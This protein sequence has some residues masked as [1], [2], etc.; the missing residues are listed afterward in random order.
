MSIILRLSCLTAT[1]II[2]ITVTS[3]V[4]VILGLLGFVSSPFSTSA[5][6]AGTLYVTPAGTNDAPC[7]DWTNACQLQ[8]AL[9]KATLGDNIWVAAGIYYPGTT[10]SDTFKLKDGVAIYG[11]FTGTETTLQQRDWETNVTI[12][13]GDIDQNDT[14]NEGIIE[15]IEHIKGK[16]AAYVVR[17]TGVTTTTLLDGFFITAATRNGIHNTNSNTVFQNMIIRGNTAS[18]GGGGGMYNFNSTTVLSNVTFLNN[19]AAY[20]GGGM[21]NTNSRVTMQKVAFRENLFGAMVNDGSTLVITDVT[22][23]HNS[24]TGMSNRKSTIKMVHGSFFGNTGTGMDN[25]ESDVSL[26]SGSILGSRNGG[27]INNRSTAYLYNTLLSTNNNAGLTNIN[28]N[29]RITNGTITSNYGDGI[30]NSASH[31]VVQNSIVWGNI[32]QVRNIS[33]SVPTFT[34][35]LVQNSGGSRDWSTR[36]GVDGGNNMDVDP[37]F[38]EFVPA[39]SN[40]TSFGNYH[41]KPVSAA[42]DKGNYGLFPSEIATDLDGDVRIFNDRIDLGAYEVTW[43]DLS[44]AALVS[45]TPDRARVKVGEKITY[46]YLVTNTGNTFLDPVTVVDNRLGNVPLVTKNLVPT[47]TTTGT[48][49]TLVTVDDYPGPLINTLMMTSTIFPIKYDVHATDTISV[50]VVYPDILDTQQQMISPEEGGVITSTLGMQLTFPAESVD[51]PITSTLTMLELPLQSVSDGTV[52]LRSFTL[53]AHD[54]ENSPITTTNSLFLFHVPYTAE[55]VEKLGDLPER[56]LVIGFWD[57][58][59]WEEL[60]TTVDTTSR[61]ASASGDRFGEFM[62]MVQRQEDIFLPF[63]V[64]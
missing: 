25:V 27:M 52:V 64:R 8:T 62:L 33:T 54:G 53:E 26:I 60:P 20:P 4:L 56:S 41:L 47:A 30:A 34:Y 21:Y 32:I 24:G 10:V 5:S 35:S 3:G 46:T 55:D 48:L 38:V 43:K 28:S 50:S 17:S 12:L 18:F 63:V 36:M 14:S 42:I 13:S 39:S 22:F 23:F 19:N 11:G 31:P 49:T 15:D 1:K 7:T 44:P 51:T 9:E 2:G 57:G 6:N 61:V 59:A 40:P 37:Q 45:I 29:V 58:T 16:N